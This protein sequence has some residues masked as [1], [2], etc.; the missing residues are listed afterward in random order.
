MP[1]ALLQQW[2]L[3]PQDEEIMN[4]A[5]N[6][7]L[8]IDKLHQ[9]F[10]ILDFLDDKGK[11]LLAELLESVIILAGAKVTEKNPSLQE[12]AKELKQEDLTSGDKAKLDNIFDDSTKD[13]F[14]KE[15]QTLLDE[16]INKLNSTVNDY[17]K[18]QI[19]EIWN[20]ASV[21]SSEQI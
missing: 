7:K 11:E 17:K 20:V 3:L 13:L 15:L 6:T 21:T 19:L 16:Y 5:N 4:N 14:A 10:A 9:V 12:I 18:K 1:Q 8:T 2:K